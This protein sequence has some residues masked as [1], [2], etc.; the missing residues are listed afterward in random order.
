MTATTLG[1]ALAARLAAQGVKRVFGIP[2]VHNIELYRGLADAGVA[3]T[4]ARH[5]QGAG[6]M[7]DGYARA[8]G[9]PGVAFVISGPGLTN[10]LTP[11]GQAYSDS[12]PV[13][14]VSSCLE[15]HD[16]GMG[17][18]RLHEMRN[19]ELAAETVCAWSRTAATAASA[20]QLVDRA[21]AGFAS[22]RPRPCHMQV[23]IDVLEANAGAAP[24][25]PPLPARARADDAAIDAAASM[26]AAA[27]RPLFI[28]GGGVAGAADACRALVGMTGGASFTTYAGRGLIPGSDPLHFGPNLASELAAGAIAGADLVIAAG[29]ELAEVDLWRT[30]LGHDCPLIRIDIDPHVLADQHGAA[31]GILGDG[32]DALARLADRLS[33]QSS[34]W[35]G[36]EVADFRRRARAAAEAA[37]PGILGVVETVLAALPAGAVIYSDMTQFAYTGKTLPLD[38]PGTWHHPHGFGTLG[39]ALPA[40]IGGKLALGRA[41]PVLA[42]AGDYGFQYTVQELGTA[43]EEGLGLPILIWDNGMLKEI[44]ASMARAQIAP[45]A[46]TARNPDFLALAQAYGAEATEPR[47]RDALATA[48]AEAFARDVPTLIRMTPDALS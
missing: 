10:I 1:A 48:I 30:A 5:E 37:R 47:S 2:G 13:L 39:Y 17:R 6:F 33:P 44:E 20:F 14:A 25:V 27:R 12:V 3:H 15:A 34:D 41:A 28:F 21:F 23:P 11:L 22:Q 4:L 40:A 38:T 18:G 7:A 8:S 46:V 24:P 32:A 9:K 26:I 16:A 31:L 29:T 36:D 42:I 35:T 19:Q 45:V 43:V